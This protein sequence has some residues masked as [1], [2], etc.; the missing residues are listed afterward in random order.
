MATLIPSLSTC[1]SRMTGGERRFAQR[2]EAK[3]EDDYLLWYDVPIGAANTHPD[4]IILHPQRGIL[5]LEVKDWKPDTIKNANRQSFELLTSNGLKHV[6]NPLEQARQYAHAVSNVLQKDKQLT[7][8]SGVKSGHLVFPWSYGVVLTN[9]MRST[10]ESSGLGEV[11]EPSRVICQDEMFESVEAEE[12][13]QRLS[14]FSNGRIGFT[15]DKKYLANGRALSADL[16]ALEEVLHCLE[17]GHAA[18]HTSVGTWSDVLL[19]LKDKRGNELDLR[20]PDYG[21]E[22]LRTIFAERQVTEAWRSELRQADGWLLLI[23]LKREVTYPDA[24][25]KLAEGSS[26]DNGPTARAGDWDGNARWVEL[27]QILLHVAGV[28]TVSH[29]EQP[30]LAVLL[31]CYDELAADDSPPSQMLDKHLPLVSAFIDSIW[32][33]SAVSVWGLSALGC[34]LEKNS[35]NEQFINQGP[36][37]QGWVVRPDGQKDADLSRPLAW[38]LGAE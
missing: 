32:K 38:L 6:S 11:I 34:L 8:N 21:G 33:P 31:S 28:N 4:F 1:L 24:L 30:R 12:F 10:F 3:L 16:G 2:L 18:G 26:G 13:Q 17:N 5:I 36:E 19:P 22:Q 14:E 37:H 15:Y 23:R 29:R 27:L 35:D 7:L 20:W 9:V 25:A